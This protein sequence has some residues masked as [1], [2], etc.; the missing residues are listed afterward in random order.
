MRPYNGAGEAYYFCASLLD[1]IGY[2]RP[3]RNFWSTLEFDGA[4]GTT[5]ILEIPA[6]PAEASST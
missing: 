5:A 4:V 1:D 3:S 6:L 2:F